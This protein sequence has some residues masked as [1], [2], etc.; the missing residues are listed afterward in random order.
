MLLKNRKLLVYVQG[1]FAN[2]QTAEMMTRHPSNRF[3]I[4]S[5]L[6]AAD[7]LVLTG[8][9]DIN[10]KIYH[11]QIIPGTYVSDKRD[12]E[13]LLAIGMSDNKIKIGICRG[14]QL[15][16]CVPNN[17]TLWQD[18]TGHEYEDHFVKDYL[19]GE[20]IKTNSLHHQMMR[21]TAYGIVVAG[22]KIADRKEGYEEVWHRNE[23]LPASLDLVDPEVVWYPKTKSLCFQPHPEYH[24]APE[25]TEY[26]Y[27]LIDRFILKDADIM[28][29][30]A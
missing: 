20:E 10:P 14:A 27:Q 2:S 4:C 3:D 28:K 23:A 18:V 29:E 5:S 8:G 13:D 9:A 19:T 26:F 7:V 22:C 17:G 30:V 15:L 25:T 6:S 24:D 21:P 1:L 11:S 12:A 16:N